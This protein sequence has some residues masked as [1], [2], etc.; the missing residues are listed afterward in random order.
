MHTQTDSEDI[1]LKKISGGDQDA[2]HAIY[3]HYAPRLYGKLLKTLH[4]EDL[5]S[6]ILQEVFLTIWQKRALIDPSRSF[7]SYLF[8]IADNLAIELFRR[9]NRSQ[10]VMDR[11]LAASIDHYT[12]TEEWLEQKEKAGLLHKAI[13]ALPPQRKTVF[14][15]CK[16]EGKS[17]E[18]VARMLDISPSTVNNHIVKA[19]QS[20]RS[21]L[22]DHPDAAGMLLLYFLLQ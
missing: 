4:S 1:L 7:R 17:H 20:L 8:K 15:L 10:A 9:S 3:Y 16:L 19:M 13:E 12:H 22:A 2:F 14:I 21:Y 18:E 6:E 5:A 11:L